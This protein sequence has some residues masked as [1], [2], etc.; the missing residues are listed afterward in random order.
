MAAWVRACNPEVL[1]AFVAAVVLAVAGCSASPGPGQ[2]RPQNAAAYWDKS[3]LLGAVPFAR[4]PHALAPRQLGNSHIAGLGAGLRVGALFV[5]APGGN[6]FCTAS[7]VDSPGKNLLI[8]AAHC[9]HGGKGGAGYRSDI[10][11]IPDYR[12]GVE[13]F[14]VWTVAKLLVAPQ[15]ADSSDPDYDVGFVVLKS[16]DHENIQEILGA[17]RLGPDQD[18]RQLVHVTG[19]PASSDAPITCVNWASPVSGTQQRFA[20]PGYTGGTSG[21]P[22][23]VRFSKQS[24]TGTIIGVLGGY[25]EGGA[26]P[27]VSYS[28]RIGPVIE[29]LYRQAKAASVQG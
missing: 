23:V 20:C 16:H 13:P 3:R 29:R 1:A 14:G 22:W 12:D 21:S 18:S 28:D 8:T 11:F 5:R 27:Y 19:Y 9:I 25:Q 15:W 6:H 7:V 2:H 24:H 4:G 10:V 26:T 17:N